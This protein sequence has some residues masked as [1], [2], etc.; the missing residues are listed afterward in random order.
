MVPRFQFLRKLS[1]A[2]AINDTDR[3]YVLACTKKGFF[4]RV[5]RRAADKKLVAGGEKYESRH[6]YLFG[7]PDML[8]LWRAHLGA[9]FQDV[10][11]C[12]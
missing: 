8:S 9:H 5:S 3:P 4:V 11:S 12:C 2:R 1:E 10:P 6:G 7:V